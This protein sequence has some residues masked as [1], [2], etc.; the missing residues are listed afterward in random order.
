[1]KKILLNCSGASPPILCIRHFLM[2]YTISTNSKLHRPICK[3][4]QKDCSLQL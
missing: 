3:V 2:V 4:V 1:M